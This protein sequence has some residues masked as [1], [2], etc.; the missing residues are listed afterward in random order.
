MIDLRTYFGLESDLL[1]RPSRLLQYL[2]PEVR[3][4]KRATRKQ[5][6]R[7]LKMEAEAMVEDPM[8]ARLAKL[9]RHL[10][11][12]THATAALVAL[13]KSSWP[14]IVKKVK[15]VAAVHKFL[16][17]MDTG[18]QTIDSIWQLLRETRRSP[19]LSLAEFRRAMSLL[20][21]RY[22]VSVP[23]FPSTNQTRR[24][25]FLALEEILAHCRLNP[26]RML[27]FD[28]TTFSFTQNPKRSWQS[29]EQLTTYYT[30]TNFRR[31]HLLMVLG[32]N[33]V[34]AAQL[35]LGKM[36]KGVTLNFLIEVIDQTMSTAE[37][38]AYT[39][40]LDNAKLHKTA[41]V[42]ALATAST[43]TFLF[44]APHSPFMNAIEDA[45]RYAKAA[46]R[47]RHLIEE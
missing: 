12:G 34:Y 16:V 2:E 30:S 4:A 3:R 19:A 1:V 5:D 46:D 15:D 32:P 13:W 33:G 17:D 18:D 10:R 35:I 36:V 11:L 23:V 39:L 26:Q 29:P 40:V 7:T 21:F 47:N 8:A 45:F 14:S 25:V 41:D 42:K 27:F 38:Q 24:T 31:Y 44:T 22:S 9:C 6:L 43:T 37:P 20:G 28:C